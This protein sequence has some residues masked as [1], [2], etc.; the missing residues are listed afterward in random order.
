M[1]LTLRHSWLHNMRTY[2]LASNTMKYLRIDV[3]MRTAYRNKHN[4]P[5]YWPVA[6][7]TMVLAALATP[8]ALATRRH[9][10]K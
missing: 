1:A 7:L 6:I 2:P 10:R 8:A 5:N 3:P 9:M 4:A